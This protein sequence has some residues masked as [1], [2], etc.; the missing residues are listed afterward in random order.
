MFML[1]LFCF[2]NII[3]KLLPKCFA[4]FQTFLKLLIAVVVAVV[5]AVLVVAVKMVVC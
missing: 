2:E 1:K 5:A 4:S 3:R